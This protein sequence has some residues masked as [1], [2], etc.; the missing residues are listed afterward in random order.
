M[1]AA[2][3]ETLASYPGVRVVSLNSTVKKNSID[4]SKLAT[5][6]DASLKAPHAWSKGAT[7]EGVG[8]AVID[9]G[10]AGDQPDFRESQTNPARGSW[11]PR[12]ST[13]ARRTTTKYGHGTHVAGII[14]GN[15]NNRPDSDPLHGN[16]IGVAP[17]ANLISIKVSD[18]EGDATVLDV[19]YGLQF[20][21]D[22]K[23]EL[24]HPRRQ[25]VA[26]VDDAAVLQDRPA[27]RRGRGGMVQRHRR[28][29]RCGQPRRG[30]RRRRAT[31]RAT[32][33]T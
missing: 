15:G 18:D 11:R 14:A 16:Y 9:T 33:P 19:I 22:H 13:R 30:R 21:V 23:A 8:V 1:T 27:G 26:G 32:T 31:R 10:V 17:D 7:G 6:Y 12:R 28:R 2:K 5:S 3:A 4:D 25:P 20:A 29:R 24:Q